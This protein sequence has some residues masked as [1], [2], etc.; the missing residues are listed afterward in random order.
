MQNAWRERRHFLGCGGQGTLDVEQ[1]KEPLELPDRDGM[2]MSRYY[3]L[4][5]AMSSVTLE[6][7]E[8]EKVI[9]W[10]APEDN[11]LGIVFIGDLHIGAP[12]QYDLLEDDLNL[13]RK[14]LIR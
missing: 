9:E 3:Q 14:V 4:V 1:P 5:K 7:R 8:R 11:Y 13:S 10:E 6:R 2:M 12:I